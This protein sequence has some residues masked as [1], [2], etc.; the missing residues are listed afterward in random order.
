MILYTCIIAEGD[1]LCTDAFPHQELCDGAILQF[2]GAMTTNPD[3]EDE[4]II[5]IVHYNRL[6]STGFNKKQLKSYIKAFMRKVK[7]TLEGEGRN[8]E[9]ADF[10]AKA[11][12]AA[13]FILGK[14][15]DLEFYT[16]ESMNEEGSIVFSEWKENEAGETVPFFYIFKHGVRQQRC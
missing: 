2:E 13:K 16:G 15:S 3:D 4:Q 10:M 14:A 8:D 12:A 6:V 9:V 7:E 1:E 11:P 5:N